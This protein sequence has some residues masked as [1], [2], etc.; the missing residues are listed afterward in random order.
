MSDDLALCELMRYTEDEIAAKEYT[1]YNVF[2]VYILSKFAASQSMG[3]IGAGF[4]NPKAASTMMSKRF[5]A[6]PDANPPLARLPYV[7]PQ[8]LVYTLSLVI[9]AVCYCSTDIMTKGHALLLY[10]K[11][12]EDFAKVNQGAFADDLRCDIRSFLLNVTAAEAQPAAISQAAPAAASAAPPGTHDADRLLGLDEAKRRRAALT[13]KRLQVLGAS[14]SPLPPPPRSAGAASLPT[15]TP[16]PTP[17][18]TT[19]AARGTTATTRAVVESKGTVT[20]KT[21][22]T[23]S[24]A[25]PA[26][27]AA[28][29]RLPSRRPAPRVVETR[30]RIV[31][32]DTKRGDDH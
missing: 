16:T 27:T 13:S 24:P 17:T 10:E 4:K 21:V 31:A 19:T 9:S 12:C 14:R 2:A 28:R 3:L 8:T 25:A 22:T 23:Q 6:L 15:P 32:A 1:L 29:R 26:K 5:P 18:L 20:A 11:L 30:S 7:T